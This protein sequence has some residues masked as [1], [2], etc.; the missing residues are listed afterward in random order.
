MA[1]NRQSTSLVRFLGA[2]V[3]ARQTNGKL[4][5]NVKNGLGGERAS[6]AD[7]QRTSNTLEPDSIKIADY[8]AAL[9]HMQ[10]LGAEPL[11]AKAMAMVMVDSAKAQGVGVMSLIDS[12]NTTEMALISNTAYTY[13]NQL[14]DTSSQLGASEDID[15]SKSLRSR[16]LIA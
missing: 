2:E 1:V 9:S 8:Q 3:S 12:A 6:P 13:I 5:N 7:Q 16:Y 11:T 14:R 15:N 10:T 4:A